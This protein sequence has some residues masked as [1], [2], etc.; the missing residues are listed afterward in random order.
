MAGSEIRELLLG[1][2]TETLTKYAVARLI[3]EGKPS[4]E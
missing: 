2:S 3:C 1:N 4:I